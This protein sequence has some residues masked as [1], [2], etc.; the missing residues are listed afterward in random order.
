MSQPSPAEPHLGGPADLT[1]GIS[2]DV[3][4]QAFRAVVSRF[5]TG[6]TVLTARHG[7]IDHA[8]TANAF[9]SVSL[10][11]VLV[12][13]CVEQEARFSEAI[14]AAGEWGVSILDASARS[15]STWLAERGRPLARPTRPDRLHAAGR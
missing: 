1:P 2:T 13:V 6:V 10:D 7:G 14:L 3:D 8:M 9:T 5:T 4:P 11:P 15:A 12:L